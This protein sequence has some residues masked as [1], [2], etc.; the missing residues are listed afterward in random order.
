MSGTFYEAQIAKI[1]ASTRY[2]VSP[3]LK[4]P[5]PTPHPSHCIASCC[6]ARAFGD[7]EKLKIATIFQIAEV[8]PFHLVEAAPWIS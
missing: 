2:F 8:T 6:I 7:L 5:I 3:Q 4:S 1:K